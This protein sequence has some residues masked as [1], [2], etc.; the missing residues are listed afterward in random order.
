ML[1]KQKNLNSNKEIISKPKDALIISAT[2]HLSLGRFKSSRIYATNTVAK[3]TQDR[4]RF[5][6][7]LEYQN[8]L[9]KQTLYLLRFEVPS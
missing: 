8:Q 1:G 3:E 4:N 2:W 5:D 6:T 9:D 7:D